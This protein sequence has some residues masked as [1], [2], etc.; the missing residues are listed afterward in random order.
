M[1]DR[2]R[3]LVIDDDPQ[4]RSLL[5]RVLVA[6]GFEVSLEEDAPADVSGIGADHDLVLLDIS[7]P[8]DD[9]RDVL[10]RLREASD[11][12]V[13]MLT[14][15]ADETDRI[16][17]LKLGADDYVAKPFSPGELVARIESVLRRTQRPADA[18]A[19]PRSDRLDFGGLVIDL[20]TRDVHVRGKRV[21]MTAKEFD[22]LAFLARSP[23][24]VFSRE[25]LL[26]HVWS[27]SSAWQD[28]ATV[29]EHVRR[30]RRRVEDDPLNPRWVLTVRG[31]GYRFEP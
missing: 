30:V 23:R 15:I 17:G 12:P 27:S 4:V 7:L 26:D 29:T 24:Q 6:E 9:G 3:I 2:A 21:E 25:Q 22:L 14:G 10:A 11:V 1:P 13:I 8:S 5:R 20:T 16:V 18:N 19:S 31:V 28:D